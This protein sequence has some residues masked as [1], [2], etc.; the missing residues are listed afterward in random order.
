MTKKKEINQELIDA[1]YSNESLPNI[2]KKTNCYKKTIKNLWIKYFGKEETIQRNKIIR[3]LHID[4]RTSD[5]LKNDIGEVGEQKIIKLFKSEIPI[6]ELEETLKIDQR[7]IRLVWKRKFWAESVRNRGKVIRERSIIENRSLKK[8]IV[9]KMFN[10]I[11]EGYTIN[12]AAKKLN[13]SS[14]VAFN[15]V[16]KNNNIKEISI[17]NGKLKIQNSMK[18]LRDKNNISEELEKEI[19]GYFCSKM[20]TKEIA[21]FLG[22]SAY[23]IRRTFKKYFGEERYL[24]R[25]ETQKP[26]IRKKQLKKLEEAG[27]LGSKP[28]I[29]FFNKIKDNL[30][31][32]VIHHDYDLLPP[33]EIDITIPELKIAIMWDGIGH[34]KP[35]FGEKVFKQVVYRD[36]FKLIS[37]KEKGWSCFVVKDLNSKVKSSFIDE[38]FEELKNLIIRLGGGSAIKC[39]I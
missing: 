14:G 20:T 38:K 21:D 2:A 27:R 5:K 7:K 37:L 31:L 32:E 28:E 17:K 26:I 36:S 19:C 10:L 35:I 1:F 6:T 16:N 18:F 4:Q 33:F 3:K 22:T 34:F 29:Q 39:S 15:Y 23:F 13:I 11:K 30:T 9:E 12:D 25:I 8:D 24:E